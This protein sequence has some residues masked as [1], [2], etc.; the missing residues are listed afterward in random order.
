MFRAISSSGWETCVAVFTTV[1]QGGP[2]IFLGLAGAVLGEL[3]VLLGGVAGAS[4]SEEL[5]E[6]RRA[7]VLLAKLMAGGIF[8]FGLPEL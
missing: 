3:V 1:R 8:A 2:S 6:G 4:V 5:S 7:R